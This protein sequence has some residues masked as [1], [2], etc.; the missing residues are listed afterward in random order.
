MSSPSERGVASHIPS[1]RRV[2][3]THVPPESLER[4]E[5][6][7]VGRD[8][9][10]MVAA[11]QQHAAYCDLLR[12][13][14]CDVVT[15]SMNAG[16]ADAV[17]VE[18][19]ALVFDEIAVLTSPGAESRRGEI[20]GM[21]QALG[22]HRPL[23]RIELPATLDGG[24]VAVAGRVIL[25]GKS[26]RT[27]AEGAAALA[28]IVRP[29]GYIVRRVGMQDCLH[30]KSACCALPDGRLLVNPAWLQLSDLAGFDIVEIDP[31]E[32]FAAD[33]LVIGRA[34]V[35]AAE[36]PRTAALIGALGFDSRTTD[37][38]EFAKA[39][40]GV[41]CLSLVFEANRGG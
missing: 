9:I 33:I 38:G 1:I 16:F 8:P 4:G 24:D 29:H 32:P 18:D 34:V 15:L 36:N 40:G 23:E 7:F 39:E 27:N 41:T 3:I 22:E 12:G 37:L 13:L 21:A 30:L 35:S 28:A 5:R 11:R 2:A 10:N 6:S 19:T 14:G 20:A 17:F 26:A 31:S 25:V